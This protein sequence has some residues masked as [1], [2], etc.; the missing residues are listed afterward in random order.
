MPMLDVFNTDAFNLVSLTDSINKLPYKP[1]R[2]GEMNIFEDK[3]ISTLTAVVE[4]K[5]GV[6][7]LLASTTR[8]AP[9]AQTPFE[10]RTVRSFLVPHIPYE[11][12]VLAADLQNVRRF[13]SESETEGVNQVV[14]DRL[15]TMRQAHEVTLEWLRLGAL[16]GIII[17]G[18]G[19]TT[20]YNLFTEFG[21]SA[22]PDVDFLL[23]TATTDIGQKCIDTKRLIEGN[24]GMES[25][26]HIHGF[27]SPSW[28]D[29]LVGHDDVKYAYQYFQDGATLRADNRAGF[30]YKGITFEEYRG[31]IGG[32]AFLDD[33]SNGEC[34]FFP[35]GVKGLFKNYNAPADF[36]E[37]VNTIGLAVYA[38]QEREKFDRGILIHTQ[39]NPLPICTR[40]KVLVRG[41]S[42]T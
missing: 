36:V 39:S 11:S 15:E 28:F 6:L 29:A 41:K 16:K 12:R 17:D 8:G 10:Q 1:G 26:D 25:Y 3:G 5:A 2:V 34:R 27:A 13:G 4:E 18:D 19:S 35:V 42:T 23:G 38:K 22:E 30:E 9:G 37:T 20:L 40:P 24:L 31:S 7:S 32:T 33:S 14:N 21:V